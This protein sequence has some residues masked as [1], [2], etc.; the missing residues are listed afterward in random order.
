MPGLLELFVA[1]V[2]GEF[3]S[4]G[5]GVAA[6]VLATGAGV[7][8]GV[9]AGAGVGVGAAGVVTTGVGRLSTP[10]GIPLGARAVDGRGAELL[11]SGGLTGAAGSLRTGA[12]TYE[13]V[14][15]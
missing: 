6:G 12:G 15:A 10:L 3:F 13:G 9:P 8:V 14:A 4:V 2:F 1:G 5:P 7:G 11:R